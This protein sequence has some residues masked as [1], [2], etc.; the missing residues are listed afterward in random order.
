MTSDNYVKYVKSSVMC[1]LKK[2]FYALG[3]ITTIDCVF[4]HLP[5]Q[6]TVIVFNHRVNV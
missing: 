3:Y 2:C 4:T 5:P 6:N 1:K